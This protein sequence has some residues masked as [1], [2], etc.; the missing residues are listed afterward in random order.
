MNPRTEKTLLKLRKKAYSTLS[1]KAI[2]DALIAMQYEVER[3]GR[4]RTASLSITSPDGE[5]SRTFEGRVRDY[6]VAAWLFQET[7]ADTHAAAVLGM[8]TVE[9]EKREREYKARD[10]TN[11]GTCPCCFA[12]VKLRNGNIVLHGYQR[13]GLGYTVG[14]CFGVGYEP[15]EVS[16]K[17][18]E[19]AQAQFQ[20][21][22]ES[23][24]GRLEKLT[25]PDFSDPLY[26]TRG[27]GRH[28]HR[29]EV[30]K[31]ESPYD[32][33]SLR[34]SAVYSTERDIRHCTADISMMTAKIEAW[35]P[36]MK[37]PEEIARERG[38]LA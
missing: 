36:G 25:S 14:S 29:V 37:M 33:E 18:T 1:I 28:K 20:R 10:W 8:P 12:N 13:P 24:Q 15:Y 2:C 4:G 26:T 30:L 38:W 9:E 7:G 23:L 22:L 32:W 35:K 31:A 6:E 34:K 19:A 27:Y 21:T 16:T 5:T 11:T 17:G 3:S